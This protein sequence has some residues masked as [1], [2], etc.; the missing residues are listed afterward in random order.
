ME[1]TGPNIRKALIFFAAISLAEYLVFHILYLTFDGINEYALLPVRL[2][3]SAFP[4]IAAA[5]LVS[6][7][8]SVGKT[9]LYTLYISLTRF[10]FSF[11]YSYLFLV[12]EVGMKTLYALPLAPLLSVALTLI[13]ALLILA[14]Y[15]LVRLVFH[16]KKL[17]YSPRSHFPLHAT[18]FS[19]PVTLGLLLY[20]L[21]LFAVELAFEVVGTVRF[22]TDYGAAFRP[23]ELI[24]LVFSY[25][26]LLVQLI[27][28]MLFAK[29]AANGL[30]NK[31]NE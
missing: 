19:S 5:V 9:V 24:W 30:A 27:L 14:C 10:V 26:F 25:V 6:M 20:P 8:L 3:L 31:N 29:L 11:L 16:I 21:A 12:L 1:R 15:G 28:S 7:G 17:D 4:V 2:S 18:D 22:F 23:S 13:Y